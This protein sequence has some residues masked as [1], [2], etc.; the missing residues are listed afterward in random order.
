MEEEFK[1]V[2]GYEGY[3]QI[4]NIG[5][6]KSLR[7][8]IENKTNGGYFI[9]EK[10]LKPSIDTPGYKFVYLYKSKIKR[11]MYIHQ[12]VAMAFLNHTPCRYK[13]VV[14]HIDNNKLNNNINNLQV[15]THRENCV[16]EQKNTSGYTGVDFLKSK[17]KFRAS[18]YIN[19]KHCFLG[20][21]NTAKEA[22]IAYQNK[23]KTLS[24]E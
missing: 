4:S 24:H 16:K 2:P 6:V 1:D 14:D 9:K 18:I 21:F 8:W 22:S 15:V 3:Y 10:Y 12:L 20:Y 7:R 11:K 17:S 19:R 5:R 23:L 13:K